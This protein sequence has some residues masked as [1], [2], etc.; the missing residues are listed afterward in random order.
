MGSETRTRPTHGPWIALLELMKSMV[1]S[2]HSKRM[3]TYTN[4]P[5]L[6]KLPRRRL[7]RKCRRRRRTVTTVLRN[8]TTSPGL[9]R[10][11]PQ[12]TLLEE[13]WTRLHSAL[14]MEQRFAAKGK[15]Q[16]RRRGY[17]CQLALTI[18]T[19]TRPR[20]PEHQPQQRPP[21]W[22]YWVSHFLCSIFD[23]LQAATGR[24]GDLTYLTVL[25]N[26][27]LYMVVSY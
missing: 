11:C 16:D 15:P 14:A 5:C 25:V 21:R 3:P 6:S 26:S 9:E 22:S 13:P 20:P 23:T 8:L 2:F 7:V 19:I 17:R 24:K 4:T 18:T 1:W 12:P 27:S 10:F